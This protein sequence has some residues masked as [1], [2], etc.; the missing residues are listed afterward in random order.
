M[1]SKEESKLTPTVLVSVNL[2]VR[3]RIF[4]GCDW[5]PVG[6]K[7]AEVAPSAPPR[8]LDKKITEL[9]SDTTPAPSRSSSLFAAS[10]VG[11]LCC[12]I[13]LFFCVV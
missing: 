8:Q 4:G 6:R 11:R 5:G 9:V 7:G 13:K 3:C 2:S 10:E 1:L 12:P